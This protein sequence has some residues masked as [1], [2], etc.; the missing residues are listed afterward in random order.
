MTATRIY[1]VEVDNAVELIRAQSKAQAIRHAAEGHITAEVA[2]Q[3]QLVTLAR[4]GM[5]VVDA[6]APPP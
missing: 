2:T 1:Y 3:D 6:S 5:V 4:S